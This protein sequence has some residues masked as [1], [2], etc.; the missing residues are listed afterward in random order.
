MKT[1]IIESKLLFVAY[2]FISL[3]MR[4]PTRGLNLETN[5]SWNSCVTAIRKKKTILIWIFHF[6]EKKWKE[7][8]K[9][10]K[11]RKKKWQLTELEIEITVDW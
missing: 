7:R 6:K 4:K 8:K 1:L 2:S 3:V 11:E 5:K 10:W 9:K